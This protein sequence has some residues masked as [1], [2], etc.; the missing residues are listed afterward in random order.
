MLKLLLLIT[1]SLFSTGS[2]AVNIEKLEIPKSFTSSFS[3]TRHIT[4]TDLTLKSSGEVILENNQKLS[5]V[6]K[7]PFSYLIL[8]EKDV[9]TAGTQNNLKV[10][11]EPMTKYMAK[12]MFSLFKGDLS[13][14]K[15]IFE[16]KSLG[17][18]MVLTPKDETMKK[19]M[20]K[21]EIEGKKHIESIRL[22]EVTGNW[23]LIKF[24][25]FRRH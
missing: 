23:L 5:W 19:F 2:F 1:M 8:M 14:L 24:S 10:V 7:K 9:V 4:A 3:Q 16:V 6:Q 25:E 17:K 15:Q 13:K 20:S 18:T 11:N 21:V 12:I 22:E